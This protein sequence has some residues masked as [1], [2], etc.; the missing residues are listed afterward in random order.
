MALVR[1][2]CVVGAGLA[3]L[4]CALAAARAG[5]RVD[6]CDAAPGLANPAMHVDV[7]PNALRD[8]SV[9]GLGD[10]AVRAGFGYR[11][12]AIFN[13]R[14]QRLF[15][16]ATPR[17]AGK[18]FP[19]AL[20][21]GRG[22]LLRLLADAAVAHG[23]TLHWGTRVEA[24]SARSRNEP[25]AFGPAAEANADLV[26]LAA[27][28]TSPLRQAL[29]SELPT[30]DLFDQ[31]WWHVLLPRPVG[32]DQATW[33]VGPGSDK[34]LLVPV[35]LARAGLVV[36]RPA[37]ALVACTGSQVADTSMHASLH[38]SLREAL[39]VSGGPF[40]SLPDQL[41][42]DMPL[43][44]RPV[45]AALLPAPW[46]R[47]RVLCV[48]EAAHAL[49]PHLSQSTAQSLEDAVV[50]GSV[51]REGGER[52]DLLERFMARRAARAER[53]HAITRQAANWDLRPE[54]QTDQR[55]LA[56]ELDDVV[57]EPA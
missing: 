56:A 2:V 8:L 17:L 52:G 32:L 29:F 40:P 5:V 27:G 43:L 10:A 35:T 54:R 28:L 4:A 3:G 20:G 26:V 51:L 45:R 23:A 11:G 15:E 44:V 50:L 49:P 31:H 55:A 57:A 34:R 53:L 9:L 37:E 24:T 14:G 12:I 47:G 19:C 39:A 33:V 38:A 18:R 36:L 16:V 30:A 42:D 1:H 48:G 46:Y 6:V 41:R 25:L 22:A 21:L 13:E 7:A